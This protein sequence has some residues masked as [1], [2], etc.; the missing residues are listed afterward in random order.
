MNPTPFTL[1]LILSIISGL[2]LLLAI[3]AY[4][5]CDKNP[6]THSDIEKHE[7]IKIFLM[8]YGGGFIYCF[9]TLILIIFKCI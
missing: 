9:T 2:A 6:Q 7:I 8:L 4:K 3:I 5:E 1:F